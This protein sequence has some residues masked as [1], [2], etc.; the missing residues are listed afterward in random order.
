[1]IRFEHWWER[2]HRRREAFCAEACAGRG[3]QRV[4]VNRRGADSETC[5]RKLFFRLVA[6]LPPLSNDVAQDLQRR[7][8]MD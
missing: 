4:N 7:T 1:M 3:R 6:Y 2:V 8:E 5:I